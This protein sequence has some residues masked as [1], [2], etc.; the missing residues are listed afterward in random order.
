MF[1]PPTVGYSIVFLEKIFD[2]SPFF[3]EYTKVAVSFFAFFKIP[4]FSLIFA[5]Y[6]AD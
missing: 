3:F 4:L 5:F 2:Y 1:V 6:A